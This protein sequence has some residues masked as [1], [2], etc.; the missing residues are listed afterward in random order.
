MPDQDYGLQVKFF[1]VASLDA[2]EKPEF[3][4]VLPFLPVFLF[5][6]PTLFSRPRA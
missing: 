4:L 6:L 1:I 5:V 2:G 3:P